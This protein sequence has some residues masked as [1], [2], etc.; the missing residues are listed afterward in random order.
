MMSVREHIYRLDGFH[1]ILLIKQ[2]QIPCLSGRVAAYIN[3]P[4]RFSKQ[5]DVNHILMHTGTGRAPSSYPFSTTAL[6]CVLFLCFVLCFLLLF[7]FLLLGV[8][9]VVFCFVCFFLVVGFVCCFVS[10]F[11]A[12]GFLS[13]FVLLGVLWFCGVV[14]YE[15]QLKDMEKDGG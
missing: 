7:L 2:L 10:G 4:F 6:L 15:C 12:L 3:N 9:V 13:F 1:F 11:L 8:V 5:N 14:L